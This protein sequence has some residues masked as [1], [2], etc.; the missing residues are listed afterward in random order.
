MAKTNW[1]NKYLHFKPEVNQLFDELDAYRVFC[2]AKGL[3]YNEAH[4]HKENS[5]YGE[6]LKSMKGKEIR[7][8]WR[9]CI[10]AGKRVTE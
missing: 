5:P 7:D 4:L 6:F 3:V 2:V 8:H 9:D 1:L 10:S